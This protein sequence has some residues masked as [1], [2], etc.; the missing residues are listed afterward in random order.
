MDETFLRD[1]AHIL[2]LWTKKKTL[3]AAME[4]IVGSD[5]TVS[6]IENFFMGVDIRNEYWEF[7]LLPEDQRKN[8]AAFVKAKHNA[9]RYMQR[10]N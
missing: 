8:L 3:V 1:N 7:S 5:D 4:A 10:K 2:M 9:L 6:E